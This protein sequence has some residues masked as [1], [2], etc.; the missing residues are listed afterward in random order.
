MVYCTRGF[1]GGFILLHFSECLCIFFESGL[2]WAVIIPSII[3]FFYTVVASDVVNISPGYLLLLFYVAFAVPSF[4]ALRKHELV[5]EPVGLGISI[6]CKIRLIVQKEALYCGHRPW[7]FC[8]V[9][10]IVI[11]NTLFKIGKPGLV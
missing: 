5:A 4:P 6:R 10:Y 9:K 11:F 7:V 8:L 2:S 3:T 1:V